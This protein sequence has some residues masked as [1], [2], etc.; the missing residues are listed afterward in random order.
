ME[1]DTRRMVIYLPEKKFNKAGTIVE[2]PSKKKSLSLLEIQ[3]LTGYLNFVLTV[4][5][6]GRTLL[7]GLSNMEL[8]FPQRVRHQRQISREAMK[9]ITWWMEALSL[10]PERSIAT[11]LRK[12]IGVWSDAASTKGLG[13]SIYIN[14]KH[15][16]L[17]MQHSQ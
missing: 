7:Q 13:T 5:P 1:F 15:P 17:V 8:Y 14:T 2:N 9:D 4:I 16:H 3:K 12:T 10:A 11:I 6:L